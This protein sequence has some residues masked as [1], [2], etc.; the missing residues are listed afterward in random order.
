M[1]V[2]AGALPATLN[3]L[4]EPGFQIEY[5]YDYLFDSDRSMPLRFR[6]LW[7]IGGLGFV[8]LVVYLSLTPDPIDLGEP[9]GLKIGHMVAYGWLMIWFA[10]IYRTMGRRLLLAA[11]FCAL[12]VALEYLQAMTDYR[13][14][15]YSDMLFNATGLVVGLVMAYTPLQNCLRLFETAIGTR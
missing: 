10:Q 11:A 7:I 2:T 14:F 5:A 1:V 8:L 15:A 9:E 3:T 13:V 4:R 6:R 12:G